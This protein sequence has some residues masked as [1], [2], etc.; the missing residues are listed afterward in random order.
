MRVADILEI[1][2]DVLLGRPEAPKEGRLLEEN[3]FY[4]LVEKIKSYR[5]VDYRKEEREILRSA[6][7]IL[8]DRLE[9]KKKK[10]KKN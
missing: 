2:T 1:S 8:A 10:R 3:I 6:A 4:D 9:E 5:L 7:K